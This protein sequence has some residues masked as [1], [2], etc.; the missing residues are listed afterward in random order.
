MTPDRRAKPGRSVAL[1]AAAWLLLSSAALGPVAAQT[2]GRLFSTPEQRIELDRIRDE[3]DYGK[4]PP[5][6]PSGATPAAGGPAAPAIALVTVNGVVLRSSGND[7]SWVNGS[8]VLSG[9]TTPE[10]IRVEPRRAARAGVRLVLPSGSDTA[11][12]RPGQQIDVVNGAVL[13]S[14]QGTPKREGAGGALFPDRAALPAP[15]AE[16]PAGGAVSTPGQPEG[17]AR[18]GS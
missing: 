15:P 14:Y 10:G 5:A 1:A 9:Q 7:A 13:D 12:I 17:G 18:S 4:P 6:Q 2:I 11:L 8:A 3:Y 16:A